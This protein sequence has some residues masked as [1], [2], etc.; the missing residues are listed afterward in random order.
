MPK[1]QIGHS[2]GRVIL[3]ITG[4]DGETCKV[5]LSTQQSAGF[6]SQLQTVETMIA[7]EGIDTRMRDSH[8]TFR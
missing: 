8:E 2:D 3:H 7:L 5:I 1:V 4:A 6:R